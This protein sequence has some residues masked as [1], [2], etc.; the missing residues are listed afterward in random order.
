M[1]QRLL[2]TDRYEFADETVTELDI[3]HLTL[4]EDAPLDMA[5]RI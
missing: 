2:D 1:T 4:E 5:G 3:S